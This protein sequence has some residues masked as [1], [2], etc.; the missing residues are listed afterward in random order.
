MPLPGAQEA[1]VATLSHENPKTKAQENAPK[2]FFLHFAEAKKKER[3]YP[4]G[5]LTEPG[6]RQVRGRAWRQPLS[7][8]PGSSP[9]NG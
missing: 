6:S 7:G 2:G 5:A 8:S 3:H 4:K 1:R 9:N